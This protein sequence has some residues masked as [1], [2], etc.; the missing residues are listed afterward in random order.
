MKKRSKM[1]VNM[2]KTVRDW[3]SSKL[4]ELL[5]LKHLEDTLALLTD[6]LQLIDTL[7][8]KANHTSKGYTSA[9][10]AIRKELEKT[11]VLIVAMLRNAATFSQNVILFHEIDF[12]DN[13][14]K[15]S[16]EQMLASRVEFIL[17]KARAHQEIVEPYGLTN[18]G[19]RGIKV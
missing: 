13:T 10:N 4:K 17:G 18:Q 5:G 1:R 12:R 8:A 16:S 11:T 15:T 14:F 3:A 9:K 19:Y 2:Y 7:D 6:Q